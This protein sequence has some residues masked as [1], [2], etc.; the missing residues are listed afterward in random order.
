[1]SGNIAVVLA[2]GSGKRAG[3]NQPKQFNLLGDKE[4]IA[5]TLEAFQKHNN[6]D[7]VHI[8]VGEAWIGKVREIV[9]REG[10]GKVKKI[11]PG[12]V[13][14]QDS[15]REG[16]YSAGESFDRILIHDAARPF[17]SEKLIDRILTSLEKNSAVNVAIPSRDTVVVVNEEGII[18]SVPDRKTLRLV[19]TPQAFRLD[20]IRDAH[21][22]AE[23]EGFNLAT[24]DC[25]LI[26]KY[27]LAE[28]A[29]VE[30][31]ETNIKINLSF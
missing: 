3:G 9:M 13:E 10:F 12:G 26:L 5:H 31:E 19:Q 28:V 1:M 29:T 7:A 30:G 15:S 23:E 17:V 2:G 8:V 24:D 16:V 11:I 18:N 21:K 25:S 6:I 27:R 14:R 22:R 4:I 20:M